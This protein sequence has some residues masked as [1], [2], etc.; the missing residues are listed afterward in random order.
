MTR[1]IL[2]VSGASGAAL[3]LECA[4]ILHRAG[5]AIDG[6]GMTAAPGFIDAHSHHERGGFAD[7]AM[8]PLLAEGV[9]TVVI[10][11]DGYGSGPV[12]DVAAAFQAQAATPSSAR[13]QA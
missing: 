11:Q 3:A 12:R 4:K 13:S 8:P 7:R 1:V 2:G 10:G 6:R 9:T 5:V